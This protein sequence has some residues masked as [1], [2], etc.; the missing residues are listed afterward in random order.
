[1]HGRQVHGQVWATNLARLEDL[2][3]NHAAGIASIDLFVVC[4]ISFQ[5][6]YGLVILQHARRKLARVDVTSNPTAEWIAVR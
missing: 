6:L 1:M 2:L 5:L 3:R 4:T